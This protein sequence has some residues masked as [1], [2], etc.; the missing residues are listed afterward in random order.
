MKTAFGLLLVLAGCLMIAFG[1]RSLAKAGPLT[2][3]IEMNQNQAR[4][5]TW[6]GGAVTVW[7]GV[8]LLLRR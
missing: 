8:A 2:R 3:T 4:I 7:F 1:R 6:V 5:I